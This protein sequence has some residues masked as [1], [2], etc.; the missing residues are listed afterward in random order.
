MKVI[1]RTPWTYGSDSPFEPSVNSDLY[2]KT[3]ILLADLYIFENFRDNCI[4]S[5]GLDPAYY[6]TLPFTWDTMLKH[7]PINFEFLT[8]VDMILFIE[9]GICGGLSQCSNRYAQANN[10]YQS[11]CSR[12]IHRNHQRTWSIMTSTTYTVMCQPL[13][14]TDIHWVDN[15]NVINVAL[16][17]RWITFSKLTWYCNMMRTP[18]YRFV[19]RARNH[20]A[21]R[22]EAPCDIV[23]NVTSYIIA[24]CNNV[25]TVS[26]LQRSIVYCNSRNLHGFASTS[27][28]IQILEF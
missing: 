15:F 20:S 10:K 2:L 22:E 6:Y 4:I 27:N 18:I 21:S 8:D 13:P 5:Y 16:D 1:T 12:M 19:Q 24:I 26:A 23:K 17:S 3:D 28:S 11:T 14:Y 9:C 25:L 7:T